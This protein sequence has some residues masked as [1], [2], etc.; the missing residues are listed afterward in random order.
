MSESHAKVMHEHLVIDRKEPRLFGAGGF[1]F[2]CPPSGHCGEMLD[3]YE[4]SGQ[5]L[6]PN[7]W[8]RR[9]DDVN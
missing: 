7:A 2:L 3:G 5:F 6:L 9:I 1:S 4:I 8:S